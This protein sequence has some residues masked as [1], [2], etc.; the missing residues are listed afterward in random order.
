ML[1]RSPGVGEGDLQT[2]PGAI[3]AVEAALPLIL[4]DKA[5][6]GGSGKGN[7]E[8]DECRHNLHGDWR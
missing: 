5:S 7:R 4:H 6:F 1:F 3:A 8:G 2:V